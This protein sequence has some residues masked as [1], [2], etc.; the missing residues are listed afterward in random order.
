MKKIIL[1]IAL[2]AIFVPQLLFAAGLT[3]NWEQEVVSDLAGWKLFKSDV[4]GSGY[5][6][7]V[8]V[9][10]VDE[11][12]VYTADKDIVVPGD[13]LTKIYFILT[14]YDTNGNPSAATPEIVA[15]IDTREGPPTPK[16][17]KVFIKQ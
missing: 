4:S 9:A 5:V 13:T 1:V 3:F 7:F 12:L 6:E 14:S 17:F 10:F 15:E 16:N 8:D 11:Q 2:L